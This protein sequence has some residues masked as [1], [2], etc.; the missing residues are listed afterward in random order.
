M[1]HKMKLINLLPNQK[2][3]QQKNDLLYLYSQN[4]VISNRVELLENANDFLLSD[5]D[6]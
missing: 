3:L 5:Y 1:K 6:N 4:F 2:K